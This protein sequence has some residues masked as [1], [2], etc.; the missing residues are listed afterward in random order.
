M[1][2][3]RH[4]RIGDLFVEASR[5]APM[6]RVAF[7]REA[8]GADDALRA[9]VE[10][11]LGFDDSDQLSRAADA[12]IDQAR[13]LDQTLPASI[14]GYRILARIGAGG[15]GVVY[16]A[17]QEEPSRRVALKVIRPGFAS[18]NTLRRLRH[19]AQVLGWLDHPCIARVYEAGTDDDGSGPRPWFAMELVR[20]E[21][22]TRYAET[23]EL[24]L[25]ARLELLA[26]VC[27]AV[28]H[29][30]QKGVI[31]RDLKPGNI[32]VDESGRP[33]VLDF[34]VARVTDQDLNTTTQMTRA[35]EVI[36]TLAYMSPEQIEADPSRLDVRSDVY[37]LGVVSYELLSGQLPYDIGSRQVALAARVIVEE[38]PASLGTLN[39]RLRGDIETIVARALEK[40]PERRY[41]SAEELASDIRRHLANEPIQARPPSAVYQLRKFAR[42]NKA[43]VG[44]VIGIFLALS[45]G[46]IVSTRMYM[47]AEARRIDAVHAGQAAERARFEEAKQKELAQANLERAVKAEGE[48]TTAARLAADDR[49]TSE[50][51]TEYLVTMFEYA[52]PDVASPEDLTARQMLDQG[53]ERI[54]TELVDQPVVRARLLNV[55]GKIYNWLQLYDASAPILVEAL[56]LTAQQYGEDSTQYADTLERLAQT[57]LVAGRVAESE[58]MQR[59]VL[60]IRLRHLGRDNDLTADGMS[61]LA[62]SLIDLAQYD[63]AERLYTEAL[64]IRRRVVGERSVSAASGAANLGVFYGYVGREAESEALLREAL[65]IF[66]EQL[67]ETHWRT[68]F[69]YA[70]LADNL[71]SGARPE[72]AIPFARKGYEGYRSH[73]G[74]RASATFTTGTILAGALIAADRPVDAVELL[75]ELLP[76]YEKTYGRDNVFLN[77]Y[78]NLG[79][80]KHDIGQVEEAEAIY[81]EAIELRSALSGPTNPATVAIQHDLAVLYAQTDRLDEAEELCTFVLDRRIEVLGEAH[82]DTLKT[83]R[84]LADTYERGAR[85]EDAEAIYR[86]LVD[87]CERELGAADRATIGARVELAT[88]LFD[89]LGN[90]SEAEQ[91]LLDAW[92]KGEADARDFG[93][94]KL[95]ARIYAA[96]GRDDDAQVWRAR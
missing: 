1:S 88:L 62:A 21:P 79:S 59:R 27:D 64:E 85:L 3:E 72:E 87:L 7:L 17:E 77:L 42:R 63:E 25:R 74:T 40:E 16:E 23:H 83:W 75:E 4:A 90:A 84:N 78:R 34:G 41:A 6:D 53:A 96:E 43:F 49:D 35:D 8:C 58:E 65:S 68:L 46:V 26:Q 45:A 51:V 2:S 10:S 56:E 19:E 37:A 9:E 91:L 54:R 81:L 60:D 28:H 47:R 11:L 89:G 20:G 29:A 18:E 92:S 5:L 22:L 33:R 39:N 14:G 67:G 69:A 94:P 71:M 52:N 38:E 15:M 36:G 66:E 50:A 82:P 44:G 76:L 86:E 95:L 70:A 48:A 12:L 30:H 73:F 24:T 61:N 31:H 13:E 57:R 93:A 80:A 32:L 55:F